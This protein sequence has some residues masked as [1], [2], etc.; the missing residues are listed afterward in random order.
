MYMWWPSS[1]AAGIYPR[2]P[3]T[4][5]PGDIY[6]ILTTLIVTGKKWKSPKFPAIQ[7]KPQI[8]SN[9]GIIWSH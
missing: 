8:Y 5:A 7:I 4:Y 1:F 2:G 9:K 6:K 3:C